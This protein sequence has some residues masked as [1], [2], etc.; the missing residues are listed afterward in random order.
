MP[1]GDELRGDALIDELTLL[2]NRCVGAAQERSSLMALDRVIE[3]RASR[4]S[5]AEAEIRRLEEDRMVLLRASGCADES[6]FRHKQHVFEE[7]AELQRMVHEHETR[8]ATIAGDD[9]LDEL[10]ADLAAGTEDD[11]RHAAS[12]AEAHIQQTRA[13]LQIAEE[14][15]RQ[16][17]EAC[18]VLEESDEIATLEGQC[19]EAL[20]QLSDAVH[21]WRVFAVALGLVEDSIRELEEVRVPSVLAA[22]STALSTISRGQYQQIRPDGRGTGLV[23]V[24]QQGQTQPVDGYSP[25]AALPLY[26]STRLGLVADFTHRHS[27]MPLIIDDILIGLDRDLARGITAALG[28]AAE[29]NQVLF[30]TCDPE[31]CLL[32]ADSGKAARVVQI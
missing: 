25:A 2:R 29:E 26:L 21:R 11:W 6:D 13:S 22:A 10:L 16:A 24:D 31:T 17:A 8:L 1:V 3:E 27:R 14:R 32:L 30:F 20:A 15:D 23:V 9:K 28:Q 5:A 7:R 4:I 19:S 12:E 18:R